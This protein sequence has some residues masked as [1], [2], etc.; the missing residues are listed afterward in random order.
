[1]YSFSEPLLPATLIGLDVAKMNSSLLM[2]RDG[3]LYQRKTGEEWHHV[4]MITGVLDYAQ[5]D[6]H[7]IV[8]TR[9]GIYCRGLNDHGQC[10][11]G[12]IIINILL[13]I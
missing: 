2:T 4:E 9:H 10:G 11:L 7:V 1:M 13:K 5:S 6:E 12:T 3:L 8:A